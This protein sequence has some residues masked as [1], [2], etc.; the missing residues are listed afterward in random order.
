LC[1]VAADVI[2]SALLLR[3]A[4]ASFIEVDTHD[5]RHLSPQLASQDSFTAPDIKR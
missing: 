3:Q 1:I 2:Q 4:D 5:V